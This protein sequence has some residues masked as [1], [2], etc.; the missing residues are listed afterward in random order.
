MITVFFIILGSL[1]AV[2]TV[3]YLTH[4]PDQK[5]EPM[6]EPESEPAPGEESGV[7]C[8]LHE[9][10]ERFGPAAD[11]PPVYFDDEELDRFAGRDAESYTADEIDE[12]REV[13]LT[14][15]ASDVAPWGASLRRRS[16]EMPADLRD[17]YLMLLNER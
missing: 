11:A 6:P 16:I 1:V 4:R 10:C 14:L 9:V 5:P 8:G 3:L 17:E 2:G 7:C 15:I 13:M 12:F